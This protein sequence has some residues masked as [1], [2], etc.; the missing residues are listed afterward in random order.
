[1]TVCVRRKF[2]F[3]D[4]SSKI[5]LL[6]FVKDILKRKFLYVKLEKPIAGQIF[7]GYSDRRFHG[8]KRDGTGAPRQV[9]EIGALRLD[10]KSNIGCDFKLPQS[11]IDPS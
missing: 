9:L 6:M 3:K 4:F 11:S 5:I 10:T 7:I 1:M 8:D 2:S